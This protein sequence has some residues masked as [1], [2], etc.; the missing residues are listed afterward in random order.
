MNL[1][2]LVQ[3]G[4]LERCVPN[5]VDVERLLRAAR[6]SLSDAGCE[7]ITAPTRFDAAYEAIMQAAIAALLAIGYRTTSSR[8]GHH[9]IAIQSLAVTIAL[10]RERLSELD[11]YRRRRNAND[12]Y[13][14]P[15]DV[16]SAQACAAAAARLL[17]EAEAAIRR[18]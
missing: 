3:H 13:G 1:P 5:A 6:Q 18:K 8:G 10:D 14:E 2:N 16:A 7:Q 9:T 15:I 17:K 4:R 11:R 12:Y